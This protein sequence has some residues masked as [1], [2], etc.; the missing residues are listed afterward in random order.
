MKL[1]HIHFI[2]APLFSAV[3]LASHV[4]YSIG[5]GTRPLYYVSV[6]LTL[7]I[8]AA[9]QTINQP[10][11]ISG[12][13]QLALGDVWDLAIDAWMFPP[14][15]SYFQYASAGTSTYVTVGALLEY[16]S[17]GLGDVT[18][19]CDLLATT[20]G[21]PFL[22]NL[23]NIKTK[24]DLGVGESELLDMLL[25]GRKEDVVNILFKREATCASYTD[26]TP[27]ITEDTEQTSDTF[28]S[29]ST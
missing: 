9:Y 10:D 24:R 16:A 28:G 23:A 20:L 18:N 15:T 25:T 19:V 1:Q 2:L 6:G 17:I 13:A 5:A 11:V 29:C 3:A 14:Q 8:P 22:G 26:L 4:G 27:Y 7:R 12:L 21:I